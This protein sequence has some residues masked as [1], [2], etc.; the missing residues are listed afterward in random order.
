[1]TLSH[2]NHADGDTVCTCTIL[3]H[4]NHIH[5]QSRYRL[6]T[7]V[8]LVKIN[9]PRA[10]GWKTFTSQQLYIFRKLHFTIVKAELHVL[11]LMRKGYI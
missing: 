7:C 6:Y 10:A 9:Y 3:S 4:Y 8:V 5:M 2:L 1:M 11:D